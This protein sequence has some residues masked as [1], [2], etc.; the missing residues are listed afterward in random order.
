MKITIDTVN[1]SKEEIRRTIA[2]LQEIVGRSSLPPAEEFTMPSGGNIF[3][4][5]GNDDSSSSSVDILGNKIEREEPK[6]K[7]KGMFN[8]EI[9]DDF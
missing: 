7:K 5:L 8:I 4:A 3:G 2:F 9:V 6:E 1:D